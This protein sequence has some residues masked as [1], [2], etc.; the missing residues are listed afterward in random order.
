M[1]HNLVIAFIASTLKSFVQ[2][3]AIYLVNV[4]ALGIFAELSFVR[5]LFIESFSSSISH[6]HTNTMVVFTYL[7]CGPLTADA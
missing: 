3:S 4:I 7:Q 6:T 5:P 1:P 2:F